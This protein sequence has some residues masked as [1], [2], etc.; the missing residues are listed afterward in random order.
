M[1]E[2]ALAVKQ[3]EEASIPLVEA[4]GVVNEM[5][6]KAMGVNDIFVDYIESIGKTKEFQKFFAEKFQQ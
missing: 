4:I 2:I 5:S 3:Q 1:E 6:A